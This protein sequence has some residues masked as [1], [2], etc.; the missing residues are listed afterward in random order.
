MKSTIVNGLVSEDGGSV[1]FIDTPSG[2]YR[3]VVKSLGE[4][5]YIDSSSITSSSVDVS[6]S[7][8]VSPGN[9]DRPD[10]RSSG[11]ELRIEWNTPNDGGSP[12][13]AF[14]V[15]IRRGG[16]DD[17]NHILSRSSFRFTKLYGCHLLY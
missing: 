12:I 1:S 6:D 2:T 16:T 9:M 13:I 17:S 8:D 3:A 4:G 11:T 10:V 14:D 5:A 15:D 7:A